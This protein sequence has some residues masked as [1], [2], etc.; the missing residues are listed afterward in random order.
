M[1]DL[2]S[3]LKMAVTSLKINKMRSILTSLGIIIGV[4]AVIIMISIGSGTSAKI[5][6]DMESMGSNLLMIRSSSATSGGVRMGSGTKPSLT[7]KDA[8][9][10]LNNASRVLAVTTY[11]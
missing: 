8:E 5:A 6:K 1:M 7:L 10:I 2:K 9:I 11:T 4:S 3:I